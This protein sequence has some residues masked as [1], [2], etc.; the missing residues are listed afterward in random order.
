MGAYNKVRSAATGIALAM[1]VSCGGGGGGGGGG[2]TAPLQYSGNT[3]A[4]VI[5]TGNA[6]ALTANITG[7]TDV[8]Q[9]T[10][11]I[12]PSNQAASAQGAIDLNRELTR[13]FRSTLGKLGSGDGGLTSVP[14]DSGPLPCD[15]GGTVRVVG[16]VDP[17]SG[18]GT[19]TVTYTNCQVDQDVLNGQATMRI[20]AAVTGVVFTPTDFTITF[21]RLTVRGTVNTDIAGS[22]RIVAD[23]FLN[24]ETITQ[25]VVA[26]HNNTGRMTKSENMIYVN[27][28]DNINNPTTFTE[29]MTGRLFDSIHGFVDIATVTPLVFSDAGQAFP[30]GGVLQLAGAG[31]R[32][33]QATALSSDR[34]K[35]ALDI[36]NVPGFEAVAF[37]GWTELSGPLG[38]DL[39]DSD[40]DGMH[41]SWETANP[42]ANDPAV[43]TDGDGFSNL[44]E[45]LG[46][47]NPAAGGSKP[48]LAVSSFTVASD[49]SSAIS[50]T[51]MPGRSSIASDGTN[52]LLVT[53]RE[54]PTPGVY[55]TVVSDGGQ[56]LNTFPI[57]NDTCPQRTAVAYDGTN[58]LVVVS[59]NGELFG[60]RVTTL[61][62]ILDPGGFLIVSNAGGSSHFLPAAAFDGTNYLVVWRKFTSTGVVQGRV[63]TP[64]GT[65]TGGDFL[66]GTGADGPPSVAFGG[67]HYL[68]VWTNGTTIVGSENV[69]GQFVGTS[70]G[71]DGGPINATFSAAHQFAGGL[72]FDG[73]NFLVVWDHAG[74][75]GTFPPPDG[76]VFG[77]TVLASNGA[78]G[79]VIDIATGP[80]PNHS[81]SVT[82]AGSSYVVTW[83]VSSFPNFPPAGI[84]AA[85]V[86]K[87]GARVDGLPTDIGVPV[88]GSPP[89]ASRFVN[90]VAASKGQTAL[91]SWVNNVEVSGQRKDIQAVTLF[92]P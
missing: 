18:R 38:A 75:T 56:V 69:V 65:F 22:V 25:N 84:Y 52:Y 35:I 4:A 9:A 28:Y 51:E 41:N 19:A 66:V 55:G 90:P 27:Q 85:R 34:V 44:S 2:G 60:I 10:S 45:Y 14:I 76:K 29:T 83:G 91:I 16:D 8:A 74:S 62:N 47:G 31:A 12:M 37:L 36:D 53:C 46:G 80:F 87:A 63:I 57:S 59:R 20:D 88:S 73:A 79:P 78:L 26:L 21:T 68:V 40:L 58:Y 54:F 61:G 32:Q 50:D 70:G 43:D 81:S 89:T 30:N 24:R 11:S 48:S 86:S 42:S 71:L 17:L 6:A 15:N 92:G 77:R 67:G 7:G 49:V 39:G 82:F 23:I 64:G 33:I 5:T 1:L 13:A 3:S 72:A